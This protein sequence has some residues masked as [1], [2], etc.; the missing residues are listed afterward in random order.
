MNPK[1]FLMPSIL[2]GLILAGCRWGVLQRAERSAE[3]LDLFR[4]EVVEAEGSAYTEARWELGR[5]L[6]FDPILSID[7]TLSCASCHKPALAFSD[8]VAFSPGVKGRAGTRNAPS[9]G[10]VAF[11]PYFLKEGG[12]PTLEMQVL[13]PIQEQNEFAHN[14]VDI[15]SQLCGIPEYVAMSRAAYGREPDPFVITR[16]LGTFERTL[17]S[18]QSRFD[19]FLNGDRR[20]MSVSALRGMDLFYSDRTGCKACHSGW[21]FTAYDFAN[22]ALDTTDGDIGRMRFTNEPSDRYLFKV[23]SLRNVG[24]TAPYMHDG[25]YRTL[26]EVIDHYSA[27]G[28]VNGYPE[29]RVGR[30]TLSEREKS[31]L[32]EFLRS[33][34]DEHFADDRRWNL[35][36]KGG[37]SE[38]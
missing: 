18:D 27:G 1:S 35:P 32:V 7:S 38:R 23:P 11:H 3:R 30:L 20:S 15:A 28:Q 25:R 26:E 31:D 16:A 2:A 36:D 14:I 29:P 6:F 22:N 19:R 10:N 24:L 37:A 4:P 5:K 21:N 12:V 34:S 9:L 8:S 17:I 13:V 33:L